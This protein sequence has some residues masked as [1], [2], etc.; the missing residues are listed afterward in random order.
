LR[1]EYLEVRSGELV[2]QLP[3]PAAGHDDLRLTVDAGEG[4]DAA[5]SGQLQLTH[6]GAFGTEPDAV[7]GV[8]HIAAGDQPAVIS[9][10]GG[11]DRVAGVGRVGVSHGVGGGLD[12]SAEPGTV[13]P[14]V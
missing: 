14:G 3:A 10:G 12:Q 13:G 9:Q 5:T 2:E 8:L 11:A 6:Q 7:G 1:G 4:G